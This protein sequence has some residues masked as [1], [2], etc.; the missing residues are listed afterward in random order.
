MAW[1][2]FCGAFYL[3]D[4][5][6]R[7]GASCPR[8]ELGNGSWASTLELLLGMHPSTRASRYPSLCVADL[9]AW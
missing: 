5:T 8:H 3:G 7:R 1:T 4:G 6:C 2:C 9:E